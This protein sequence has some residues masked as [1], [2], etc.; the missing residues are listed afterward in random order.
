MNRGTSYRCETPF[1]PKQVVQKRVGV[2]TLIVE[3]QPLAP[4]VVPVH[5]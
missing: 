4:A 3:Q 1:R 2:Q 5:A